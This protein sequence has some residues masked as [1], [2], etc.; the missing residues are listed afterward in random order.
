MEFDALLERHREADRRA[1][2]C[3]GIVA[4]AIYNA[5]PF[6]KENAP[7]INPLDFVPDFRKKTADTSRGMTLDQMIEACTSIFGCGPGKVS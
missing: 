3:A 5:A 2:I 6:R 1:Q 7:L 4:A